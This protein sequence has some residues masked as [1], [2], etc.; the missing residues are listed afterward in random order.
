MRLEWWSGG[1]VGWWSD[2]ILSLLHYS[3]TPLLQLHSR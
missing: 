2:E 1:V 3:I